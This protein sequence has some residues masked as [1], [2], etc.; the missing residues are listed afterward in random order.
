MRSAIAGGARP[1]QAPPG[2]HTLGTLRAARHQGGRRIRRQPADVVPARPRRP[3]GRRDRPGAPRTSAWN[4]PDSRGSSAHHPAGAA[5]TRRSRPST[6]T[7]DCCRPG[8]PPPNNARSARRSRCGSTWRGPRGSAPTAS[9][10]SRIESP[11]SRPI[12]PSPEGP[13]LSVG[14]ALPAAYNPRR[15]GPNL[16]GRGVPMRVRACLLALL[17]AKSAGA[18]PDGNRLAYLDGS[19]PYQVGRDFPKLTTPQWVGRGGGRGRRRPG[20]RRHAG[21][22]RAL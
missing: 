22:R 11:C 21:R 2:R 12:L 16:R 4:R 1:G 18:T 9:E 5:A 19:S 7:A 15:R 8:F 3:R 17:L 20:H 13:D 10:S 6:A 14:C